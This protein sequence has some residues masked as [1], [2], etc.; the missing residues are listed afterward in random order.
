MAGYFKGM[1]AIQCMIIGKINRFVCFTRSHYF[2]RLENTDN[3]LI[4]IT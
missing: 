1:E 3:I 2:F 4:T